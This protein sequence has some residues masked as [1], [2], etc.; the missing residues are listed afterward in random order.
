MTMP[1]SAD[2]AEVGGFFLHSPAS[3]RRDRMT[4]GLAGS[5]A[6]HAGV[7]LFLLLGMPDLEVAPTLI[8]VPINIVRLGEK[9]QSPTADQLASLPQERASEAA[10]QPAPAA[11]PR[12]ATPSPPV[13]RE[14]AKP[15]LPKHAPEPRPDRVA[16]LP[17]M[18]KDR[19]P[20]AARQAAPEE[21]LAARLKQLSQLRQ[22]PAPVPPAPANQDGAGWSNVTAATTLGAHGG[23]ATYGVKDFIRAQVVRHWILDR[24]P[25]GAGGWQVSIHILLEPDGTVVQSEIVDEPRYATDRAYKDFALSARNAVWLS[26]PIRLPPDAYDIARDIVVDFDSRQI[27]Q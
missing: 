20:E 22:P 1:H 12:E 25:P 24:R 15:A 19:Q 3:R 9:T 11:I 5:T 27:S 7:L 26:S 21:A 23:H 10:Q 16:A 18:P 17:P 14:A 2:P 4:A 8:V 6:L 13:Q